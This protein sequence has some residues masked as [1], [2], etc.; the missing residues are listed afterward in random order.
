MNISIELEKAWLV[1]QSH[2]SFR[3]IDSP[4]SRICYRLVCSLEAAL[5]RGLKEP[6]T[7]CLTDQDFDWYCECLM[8]APDH[9]RLTRMDLVPGLPILPQNPPY[10]FFWGHDDNG[11]LRHYAVTEDR[12]FDP[13]LMRLAA[14][15][16]EKARL[17]EMLKLKKAS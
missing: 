17:P 16:V 11:K 15:V 14:E 13:E 5:E 1:Y 8:I 6:L 7:L 9:G 3:G 4:V 10:S 2:L 12:E